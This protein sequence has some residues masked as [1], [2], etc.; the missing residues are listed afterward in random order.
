MIL[1]ANVMI[2]EALLGTI[3][4]VHRMILEVLDPHV[5]TQNPVMEYLPG[6]TN[7]V[8]YNH[9]P[10]T[11]WETLRAVTTGVHRSQR[12]TGDVPT[13]GIVLQIY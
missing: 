9:H 13:I 12:R 10:T 5:M 7:P 4:V 6:V 2:C 11:T 3:Y 8:E 1:G